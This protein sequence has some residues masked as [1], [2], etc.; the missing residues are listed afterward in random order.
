[1]GFRVL[2]SWEW[3]RR[4]SALIDYLLIACL[5]FIESLRS[6]AYLLFVV[7]YYCSSR[8]VLVCSVGWLSATGTTILA[9]RIF[10]VP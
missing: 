6:K 7:A 8:D 5:F 1:V 3:R 2:I 9:G 4:V 10:D